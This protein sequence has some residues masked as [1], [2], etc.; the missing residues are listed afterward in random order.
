MLMQDLVAVQPTIF[1][2]VP[3]V[4]D[5]VHFSLVTKVGRARSRLLCACRTR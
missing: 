1:F 2:A 3:R 5:R 4:F